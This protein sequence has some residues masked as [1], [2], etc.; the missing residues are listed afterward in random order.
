LDPIS[1]QLEKKLVLRLVEGDCGAFEKLYYYYVKR[2]YYFALHYLNN[3]SEA[4]E[5][6]QEVFTKIWESRRNI[7]ADMSFS[8]YLLTATRNTI[9]NANRK[10][11]NH[12]AYCGFVINYLQN[13]KHNMENEIIFND[14]M[15]LLNRTI[16]SLPSKRREIFKLSRNQGLSY[17]EISKSLNITEKTIETHM[18]LAIRDIKSVIEPIIGKLL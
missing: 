10:K 5:I 8:G 16:E 3:N 13:Q 6:V 18:R 14:L 11:V 17:K 7:D 9:F 12:Q 2:V 4:E 15:D 1:K